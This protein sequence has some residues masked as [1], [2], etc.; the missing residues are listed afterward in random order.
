MEHV[1]SSYMGLGLVC[2]ANGEW[3][4]GSGFLQAGSG[5]VV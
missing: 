1:A 2:L 5:L 3:C 4:E